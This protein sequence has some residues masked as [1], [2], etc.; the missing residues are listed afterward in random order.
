MTAT[1][2]EVHE[3]LATGNVDDIGASDLIR[4]IDRHPSQQVR[5]D[6]VLWMQLTGLR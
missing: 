5:I 4:V 1:I 6:L 2:V 3:T